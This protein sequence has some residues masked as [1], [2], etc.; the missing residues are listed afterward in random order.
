MTYLFSIALF[1]NNFLYNRLTIHMAIWEL[2]WLGTSPH[3][4]VTM[5]TP[6]DPSTL[7]F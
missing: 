3:P 4:P 6:D 1:Y 5:D 2:S 7:F